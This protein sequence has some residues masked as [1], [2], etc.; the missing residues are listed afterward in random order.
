MLIPTDL[1]RDLDYR[2]GTPCFKHCLDSTVSD[3][4]LLCQHC[5]P[6]AFLIGAYH[7]QHLE[8]IVFKENGRFESM[9]VGFTSKTFY[10]V[11][12]QRE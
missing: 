3:L 12:N 11:L 6:S 7:T 9:R 4:G 8:N 10:S 2:A 5:H 1:H